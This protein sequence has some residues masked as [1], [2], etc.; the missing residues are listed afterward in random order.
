M[1]ICSAVLELLYADTQTDMMKLIDA[2]FHCSI[3]CAEK[4]TL[5]SCTS[6][7][8]SGL[9]ITAR[10]HPVGKHVEWGKMAST[11]NNQNQP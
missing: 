11:A 6:V 9:S 1:E 2:F 3:K 8:H 5:C 4:K 10:S 7:L